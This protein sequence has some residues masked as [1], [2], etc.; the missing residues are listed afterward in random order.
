M[1]LLSFDSVGL[2]G[3]QKCPIAYEYQAHFSDIEVKLAIIQATK[4]HYS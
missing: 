3:I 2:S 1:D 4:V